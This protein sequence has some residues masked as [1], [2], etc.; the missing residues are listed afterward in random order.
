MQCWFWFF[1]GFVFLFFSP[2][3]LGKPMLHFSIRIRHSLLVTSAFVRS[4]IKIRM[5]LAAAAF[6]IYQLLL[7]NVLHLMRNE[8]F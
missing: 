1:V 8:C 6:L 7:A 4:L 3:K 2:T 5:N